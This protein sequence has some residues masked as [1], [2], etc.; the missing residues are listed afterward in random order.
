MS[1]R[2]ELSTLEAS[3]LI[4]IAALQPE[5]EYLFR[6][7][8]VQEAAY[9]TLLKQDRRALH[10]AAAETVLALHPDRQRELAA[11]IGMHFEQA[12]ETARAAEHL[13]VAGEQ[14]MDRFASREAMAFFMRVDELAD[15]AQTELRL[16]AVIGGAQAGWGYSEQK[17][18]VDRIERALSTAVAADPQL[19]AAAYGWAAFLRRQH[20]EA[21]E[22]SPQLQYALERAAAISSAL[23]DEAGSALPKA[24]M[25]AF[26]A[27]TGGLREGVQQMHEAIGVIEKK[28]DPVASAMVSDFLAMTYARLGD[29]DVAE[30]TIAGS[31]RLAVEG[32][33]ITRVDVAITRSML[34]LERGD[35]EAASGIAHECAARS[36]E[37][38]AYACVV[39]AN[40]IYGAAEFERQQLSEART[41]LERGSELSRVTNMA[42]FQ[43]LI[44]SLL[45]SARAEFGDLPG[46]MAR[47]D[48]ALAAAKAM[49]DRWGEAQTLRGRARSLANQPAPDWR[50][51]L[52]DLDRAERLLEAMEARP[53]I[54]R[55]LREKAEV[56]RHLERIDEPDAAD[57][58]ARSLARELDLKDAAFV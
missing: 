3:G 2:A 21:P 29:F 47:W 26:V 9:A 51:L 38:G 34:R 31:E 39:A 53:S 10:K 44:L 42:P 16:R 36:E 56:L 49:N 17:G 27:L 18:F 52:E 1:T 22:S 25:G 12:G 6:H 23:D 30:E 43:T 46:G 55:V 15:E 45:G 57:S 13:F 41:A 5:L 50:A 24:L 20:G 48:E 58:R 8:L 33:A 35:N 4:E 7:A 40:A 28:G 32:D 37:L 14:A 19:V 54:A 11:V